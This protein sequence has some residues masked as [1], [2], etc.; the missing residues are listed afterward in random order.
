MRTAQSKR[1]PNICR[2][3]VRHA[4]VQCS[5]ASF[6]FVSSAARI[7]GHEEYLKLH[8][9]SLEHNDEFWRGQRTQQFASLCLPFR[10]VLFVIGRS[11]ASLV[12]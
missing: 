2:F 3:A 7:K 6:L 5:L 9:R 12:L 10:S 1:E 11:C 4:R 8:K